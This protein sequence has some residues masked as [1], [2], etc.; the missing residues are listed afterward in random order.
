MDFIPS[1]TI[2]GIFG[3]VSGYTVGKVGKVALLVGG[4]SFIGIRYAEYN[5]ILV[6]PWDQVQS[7][8]IE[9]LDK[10]GD[11]KVTQKDFEI[12][13][14]QFKQVCTENLPSAG[15]FGLG[16]ATGLRFGVFN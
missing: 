12:V 4:V 13:Y 5:K 15:G 1:I 2:G 11:G 8:A 6:F 7:K 14:S 9:M 10:D 16:F 3:F